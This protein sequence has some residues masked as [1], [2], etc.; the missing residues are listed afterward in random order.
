MHYGQHR[1]ARFLFQLARELHYTVK[2]LQDHATEEEL[3][4]WAALYSMESED[5]KK[6][7]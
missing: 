4:L 1:D 7:R 3:I 6:G 2:D 5:R